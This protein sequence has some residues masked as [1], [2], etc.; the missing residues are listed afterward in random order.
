[1]NTS[2]R[3]PSSWGKVPMAPRN[4]G[5][6]TAAVTPLPVVEQIF[7]FCLL[8]LPQKN[9]VD[10]L[11]EKTDKTLSQSKDAAK[12]ECYYWSDQLF[13]W[14][15][16]INWYDEELPEDIIALIAQKV[17]Q[18]S[19]K[20]Y[21]AASIIRYHYL[22]NRLVVNGAGKQGV[23]CAE[24]GIMCLYPH[25]VAPLDLRR[26]HQWLELFT[27]CPTDRRGGLCPKTPIF[28]PRIDNR[29]RR[30][31]GWSGSEPQQWYCS[32]CL[33]GRFLYRYLDGKKTGCY[34]RVY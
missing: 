30:D 2:N 3:H 10:R 14:K 16:R 17:L 11:S 28:T 4:N 34:C 8:L 26:Y 5:S 24:C 18:V 15:F 9:P 32:D 20:K 21:S 25:R 27:R 12:N 22:V 31:D 19:L 6:C 7:A 13:S 1:M 23:R 33:V 29:Y